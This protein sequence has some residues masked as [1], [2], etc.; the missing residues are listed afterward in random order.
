MTIATKCIK[1]MIQTHCTNEKNS[2]QFSKI[3]K[4]SGESF[5][6]EKRG[7]SSVR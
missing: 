5:E 7:L 1:W 2:S 3:K 4:Q 6:V